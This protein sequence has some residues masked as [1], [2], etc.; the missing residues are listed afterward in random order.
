MSAS[1]GP[2][3]LGTPRTRTWEAALQCAGAAGAAA[4]SPAARQSPAAPDYGRRQAHPQG[5]L[6]R[7]AESPGGAGYASAPG[8]PLL[9]ACAVGAAA[10][11]AAAQQ[12][13]AAPDYGRRQVHPQAEAPSVAGH[14][15]PLCDR[16][17]P[18]RVI[19]SDHAHRG[20]PPL[21]ASPSGCAGGCETAPDVRDLPPARASPRA[22]EKAAAAS[23]AVVDWQR[24]SSSRGFARHPP[25]S[26]TRTQTAAPEGRSP[27]P[28]DALR[29]PVQI[30]LLGI[31]TP[32][33]GAPAPA[34]G[35]GRGF[36]PDA[37]P[38]VAF[39]GR[40]P[41][42]LPGAAAV[43]AVPDSDALLRSVHV[44]AGCGDRAWPPTTPA[45]A[46]KSEG[47]PE[48]GALPLRHEGRVDLRDEAPLRDQNPR[49]AN[50]PGSALTDRRHP[51]R[52]SLPLFG[53]R[54]PG[55]LPGAAAAKSE[56]RPEP[57]A[58]PLRHEGRVDLRDEAPL[59]D[60][61]P[62]LANTPGSALADR[63]HP[64]RE[65]LPLFG[66]RTPGGLPGAAAGK[67]APGG[68]ESDALLRSVHVPGV[69]GDRAWPPT[70]PV[71][72][73]KS[74]RRPE[75][76]SLPGRDEA[77]LRDQSSRL[78]NTPG[79]ALTD[80]GHPDRE[81]LRPVQ[82]P[83]FGAC[84]QNR[85]PAT[86][87]SA[88]GA[89]R[90]VLN[91]A[92]L[93][94][95]HAVVAAGV[96]DQNEGQP[97]REGLRPVQSPPFAVCDQHRAP[98][99]PGSTASGD[100]AHQA[101]PHAPPVALRPSGSDATDS[102]RPVQVPL[103]GACDQHR[104][105]ATPGPA[106]GVNL[107]VLHHTV[108][109]NGRP[110]EGHPDRESLCP[111]QTPVFGACDQSR[112]PAT[113]G[114]AVLNHT[115][116]AGVR[117]Q[118]GRPL[119]AVCDQN[120]VPATP[121]TTASGDC[122]HQVNSPAP[123]IA[124]RPPGSPATDSFRPVQVP[125]FG[126]HD[127]SHARSNRAAPQRAPAIGDLPLPR[128]SPKASQYGPPA[129]AWAP[130]VFDT[131]PPVRCACSADAVTSVGSDAATSDAGMSAADYDEP[132][133]D[134]PGAARQA[135]L[136]SYD[137]VL[138]PDLA[139][140][141][142]FPVCLPKVPDTHDAHGVATA[143]LSD[144]DALRL[145]AQRHLPK[146]PD[147]HDALHGM[148]GLSDSDACR[149]Q[150]QRDRGDT[151]GEC[152]SR[153]EGRRTQPGRHDS[154]QGS[155]RVA[156]RPD[157][158]AANSD[159]FVDSGL[160]SRLAAAAVVALADGRPEPL[161]SRGGFSPA[162]A[163]GSLLG[164]DSEDSGSECSMWCSSVA[165]GRAEPKAAALAA[166]QKALDAAGGSLTRLLQGEADGLAASFHHDG[167][168]E[169]GAA[170]SFS[171]S[172]A[173]VGH[174]S[175]GSPTRR[176]QGEAGGL[177]ASFHHNG[178]TGGRRKSA[179]ARPQKQL[180]SSSSSSSGSSGHASAGSPA[181]R[182]QGE[183]GGLAAGFQHDGE[184]STPTPARRKQSESTR[185][186][187]GEADA[188]FQVDSRPWQQPE[189][190]SSRRGH[191]SAGSPARRLQGEADGL[192][193]NFDHNGNTDRPESSRSAAAGHALSSETV[194]AAAKDATDSTAGATTTNAH[195]SAGGTETSASW[196]HP[197]AGFPDHECPA[198]RHL[199]SNRC[200]AFSRRGSDANSH[201]SEPSHSARGGL[202]DGGSGPEKRLE[203]DRSEEGCDAG[204]R[205]LSK[206]LVI[207][208]GAQNPRI[209]D[210]VLD[211]YQRP[212]ASPVL[213]RNR[214]QSDGSEDDCDAETLRVLLRRERAERRAA[215]REKEHAEKRA[216]GARRA[217][218]SLEEALAEKEAQ[219]AVLAA[220]KD[221]AEAAGRAERREQEVRHRELLAGLVASHAAEL[222]Q[223]RR[224]AEDRVKGARK[225]ADEVLAMLQLKARD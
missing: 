19:P 112:L 86:T 94:S 193:A 221:A 151:P 194:R 174:A 119:F 91:H 110:A 76:A 4:A 14:P 167:E 105:P 154:G 127:P 188:S 195:T 107:P 63:G 99:T 61:N 9:H 132:V 196:E 142:T 163:A 52:E 29:A 170:A 172:A 139:S 144:T 34:A 57:G 177:A 70:T 181:R 97:D 92:N 67:A 171:S 39:G 85:L 55:G 137:G 147:T 197:D 215:V 145:Q 16:L 115:V 169:G 165:S 224:A 150:A 180:E 175:A 124:L 15:L 166:V 66:G 73:A 185:L 146:V 17:P 183:V 58:L 208:T 218:A 7:G 130:P 179:Q 30:P 43:K 203:T 220:A 2:A 46:A 51:D 60:Q 153:G 31:R 182:L 143:S 192:A 98:A 122:A 225:S 22:S 131:A 149:L 161:V 117:D 135:Y 114:S 152:G 212:S 217:L 200:G 27:A 89:D 3:D 209:S 216:A 160:V 140:K 87:G 21:H 186:L 187:Q 108:D 82:V 125:L 134:G 96:R 83:L 101:N 164:R 18:P 10:A 111:V 26:C 68:P 148:A 191:A 23:V 71:S 223:E 28:C 88:A 128:S 20:T 116:A 6:G 24:S 222:K 69:R 100:C 133:F 95:E 79:S 80:R 38:P 159:G 47:R 32:G 78:A 41:G 104:L 211:P 178:E 11:S 201:Y 138:E 162:S 219:C 1:A 184:H 44:P 198:K 90:P 189:G 36:Q 42:A 64:D 118:N 199:Q 120:R 190:S 35:E 158:A 93:H 72:A 40:A 53:G 123:S 155:S 210:P 213:G 168:T 65:S 173:T 205:R 202:A 54:A 106:A 207:V 141:G 103:F 37:V 157:P 121:A 214:R 74:E 75:A 33:G 109:Q 136:A 12:S 176:L 81:S 50:T 102:L 5:A 25:A 49:L 62:R 77:P 129:H 48:P 204:T 206:E 56:G 156:V 113:P 59:R 13:P 45:S 84:D 126:A 8:T